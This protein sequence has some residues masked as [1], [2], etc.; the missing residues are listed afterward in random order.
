MK[1]GFLRALGG[2]VLLA[3]AMTACSNSTTSETIFTPSVTQSFSANGGSVSLPTSGTVSGATLTYPASNVAAGVGVT[4]TAIWSGSP[5][6][7]S[8][9]RNTQAAPSSLGTWTMTFSGS[10]TTVTFTGNF[11]LSYSTKTTG[12]LLEFFQGSTLLSVCPSSVSN[13]TATFT[14][15]AGSL[16]LGNAYNIEVVSGSTATPTPTTTP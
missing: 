2:V 7:Q 12:L 6:P 11:T 15:Q 9:M 8:E 5:M 14:C 4:F 16:S 1:I 10:T 3:G 13:G